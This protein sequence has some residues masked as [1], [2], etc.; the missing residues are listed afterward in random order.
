MNPHYL[1]LAVDLA[2]IGIPLALS[3]D[4]KVR[5]ARFWPALFP[6]IGIMMAVFMPWDIAFTANGIWGFNEAYLSGIWLLGLPLEG[7]CFSF[8]FLTHVS[9]PMSHLSTTYPT[10]PAVLSPFQP[11]PFWPY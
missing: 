1:Y 3:F 4:R 10:L 9:L 5:F 2:V 6:A 8:V 7:G 11:L